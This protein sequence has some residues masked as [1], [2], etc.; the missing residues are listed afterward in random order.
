MS[1]FS[2]AIINRVLISSSTS[3]PGIELMNESSSQ[4][5]TLTYLALLPVDPTSDG[6]S[7]TVILEYSVDGVYYNVTSNA[8]AFAFYQTVQCKAIDHQRF[9]HQSYKKSF[10]FN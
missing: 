5:G 8:S 3:L 7:F 10:F 6:A 9:V 1:I 4:N 2:P